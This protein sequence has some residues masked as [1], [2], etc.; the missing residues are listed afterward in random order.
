MQLSVI[1]PTHNPHAGRLARTLAA[2]RAQ[3]LPATEWEIVVVDN[4]S[5]PPVD[6]GT[7]GLAN[8]RLVREPQPGLTHARRAGLRAATG[9]LLVFADD[10]NVLDPD[11]LAQ[12]LRLAAA[13]PRVGAFGGRSLPGF[14]VA[15]ADWL[16]EFFPLLALRDPGPAPVIAPAETPPRAYPLCAPIGAG[17]VLRRAA[18]DAWLNA[19]DR[20]LTDR[21]GHELTSGGDNDI[22]L[23]IFGAGWDVAYFPELKLTHL[24]PA[25]RLDAGYLARL[26]RG[27]QKSWVQVLAG[28]GVCPWAA[29][30][31]WTVPLRQA[32]AW[33]THR[34][35]Q[36][37][38][39]HI[40]W[41]GACGHFEG[42]AA[43][44][45]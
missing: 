13:H 41:Q 18:A 33:F 38:A 37:T 35:W 14:E 6:A 30:A 11:Y 1:I 4:A 39:A 22:V 20:G 27:I 45:P 10:D 42:R 16:A 36:G 2:L 9:A 29:I 7:P 34:A 28:H 24:I 3:T 40:R 23:T 26:N 32:K 43:I 12:T 5:T 21:R 44:A 25:G 31:P 8:A 19:P 15:P 17:M